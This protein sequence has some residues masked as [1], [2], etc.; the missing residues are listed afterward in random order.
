LAPDAWSFSSVRIFAFYKARF[1]SRVEEVLLLLRAESLLSLPLLNGIY[2]LV[3]FKFPK[4]TLVL[5]YPGRL[6]SKFPYS[7][8]EKF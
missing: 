7:R 4:T 5:S 8:R 3:L 6:L 2:M 1:F